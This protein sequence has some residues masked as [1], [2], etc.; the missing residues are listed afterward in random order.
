[1]YQSIFPPLESMPAIGSKK[2]MA[3]SPLKM[4][5]SRISAPPQTPSPATHQ[6][7]AAK[8]SRRTISMP[9][10][11]VRCILVDLSDCILKP[12]PYLT[13]RMISSIEVT[14][15]ITSRRPSSLM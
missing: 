3:N 14:P 9:I 8:I 15:R 12:V 4:T 7:T 6:V 1:M 2:F 10:G 5:L 13:T 11:S